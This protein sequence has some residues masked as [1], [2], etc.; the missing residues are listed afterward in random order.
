MRPDVAKL[1][2]HAY[3]EGLITEYDQRNELFSR[4]TWDS[5]LSDIRTRLFAP[6][7]P[8]AGISGE[9]LLDHALEKSVWQLP[10]KFAGGNTVGN[11]GLYA[12]G[13]K[14]WGIYGKPVTDVKPE[15][16]TARATAAVKQAARLLGAS[17][18]R[19]ATLDRRWLYS[20]EYN[21]RT[22]ERKP[23]EIPDN[24][25]YVIVLAHE[26]DYELIKYSPRRNHVFATGEAY[27]RM[28]VITSALA[29]FIR[30]IGYQALPM[31]NDTALSIPLAID[32]GIGELGRHGMLISPEFGPRI[33]LSKIFT[34]LE[35]IPDQPRQFGVWEFCESCRKCAHHC[36]GRAISN[37]PPDTTVCGISNRPNIRRWTLDSEKCFGWWAQNRGDC[38]NCIRV[39]P[40]N[41]PS[42][43]LH[44]SARYLVQHTPVFDRL[45]VGLD[46]LCRYGAQRS[47]KY[48]WRNDL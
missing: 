3:V 20:H 1:G 7:Q 27:S 44:T 8:D 40:F 33:R 46:D 4:I 21:L 29:S 25:Q 47:P 36:P 13:D 26:M 10:I 42:G 15:I 35:L 37:G 41:K 12:W 22:T 19:V 9:N 16:S 45:L 23:V 38:S 34:D 43:A 14:L 28:A 11:T 18:A 48:F 17:L 39:C 6:D 2:A 32:A 31:G 24:M 30:L 5:T